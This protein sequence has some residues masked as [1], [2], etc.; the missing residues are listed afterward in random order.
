MADTFTDKANILVLHCNMNKVPRTHQIDYGDKYDRYTK[1]SVQVE[2]RVSTTEVNLIV[3]SGGVVVAGPE[4]M[5]IK[6]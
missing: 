5:P 1:Y 4:T 6:K 3:T 2:M